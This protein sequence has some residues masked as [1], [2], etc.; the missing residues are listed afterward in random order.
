MS[1]LNV[2]IW[3]YGAILFV[4]WIMAVLTEG[5][6]MIRTSLALLA[7]WAAH[8]AHYRLFG[9][10][11]PYMFSIFADVLT[12]IVILARPAGRMQATIGW[13]L[14][15]QITIH[16]GYIV[17]IIVSGYTLQAETSYWAWI[18]W[19]ATAQIALL[20]GWFADGMGR[21]ACGDDYRRFV[22]WHRHPSVP[23]DRPGVGSS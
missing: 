8:L 5:R 21:Y 23:A 6:F 16:S 11:T 2:P 13:T 12:A 15:V 9:D 1:A 3:Y 18:D 4:L 19:I 14:L 17:H 22:P 10:P 7:N 20:G